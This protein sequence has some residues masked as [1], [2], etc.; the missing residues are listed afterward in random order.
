MSVAVEEARP[1]PVAPTH[2]EVLA[3]SQRLADSAAQSLNDEA[4][5]VERDRMA[6]ATVHSVLAG[7]GWERA[8]ANASKSAARLLAGVVAEN[9]VA[10]T[11]GFTRKLEA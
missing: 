5:R 10:R 6:L 3:R 7:D 4:L 1:A 9:A 2:R 8:Y 11:H